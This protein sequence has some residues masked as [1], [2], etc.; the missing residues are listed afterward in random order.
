MSS[1]WHC[2]KEST[3]S[4]LTLAIFGIRNLSTSD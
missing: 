3:W 1:V 4:G 2:C